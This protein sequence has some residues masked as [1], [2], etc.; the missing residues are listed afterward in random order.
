MSRGIYYC[1]PKKQMKWITKAFTSNWHRYRYVLW[2]DWKVYKRDEFNI[3]I[4]NNPKLIE[5]ITLYKELSEVSRTK[6]CDW[7]YLSDIADKWEKHLIRTEE[8]PLTDK[9][10]YYCINFYLNC[11]WEYSLATEEAY[12]QMSKK[13]RELFKQF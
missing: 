7:Y 3:L 1:I 4:S 5:K 11:M 2:H 9:W 10:F 6:I 12:K 8:C 13:Q